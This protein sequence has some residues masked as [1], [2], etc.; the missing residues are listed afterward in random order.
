MF[1]AGL[2]IDSSIMPAYLAA[3]T[4]AIIDLIRAIFDAIHDLVCRYKQ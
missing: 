1:C 3:K 2:D 4:D